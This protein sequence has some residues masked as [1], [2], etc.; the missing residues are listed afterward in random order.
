VIESNAPGRTLA[1]RLG[2]ELVER[3]TM[4]LASGE[5]PILVLERRLD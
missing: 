1:D 4:K 2:F 3:R 5:Q